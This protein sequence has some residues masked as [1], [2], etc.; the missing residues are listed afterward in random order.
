MLDCK[1][2]HNV[3]EDVTWETSSIREWLN[4]EFYNT[5]FSKEEKKEINEVC[6]NNFDMLYPEGGLAAFG[7]RDTKD[8]IFLLSGDEIWKNLPLTDNYDPSEGTFGEMWANP[9]CTTVATEYAV[10][11]GVKNSGKQWKEWQEKGGTS[12][13]ENKWWK[14]NQD[15]LEKSSDWW[16][17]S[18]GWG[19]DAAAYIFFAGGINYQGEPVSYQGIGVRPALWITIDEENVKDNND[20]EIFDMYVRCA[21]GTVVNEL[22][23]LM[24]FA[25][26]KDM[27]KG[28]YGSWTSLYVITDLDRNGRL[29]LIISDAIPAS[30]Y[31]SYTSGIFEV[32]ET[33]DGLVKVAELESLG[34]RDTISTN[35]YYDDIQQKFYYIFSGRIDEEFN[36]GDW[37][38]EYFISS[39]SLWNGEISQ[40]TLGE[41]TKFSGGTWT[42]SNKEGEIISEEEYLNL[43]TVEY[44]HLNKAT[45]EFVW[46]DF[47]KIE[48]LSGWELVE[49]L[50]DTFR[51][52]TAVT[53]EMNDSKT[54]YEKF[55]EGKTTV[56]LADGF[57]GTIYDIAIHS[58]ELKQG[59][60]L[61]NLIKY[62]YCDIGNDGIKELLVHIGSEKYSLGYDCILQCKDDTLVV[63]YED[64][65][66]T[67]QDSRTYYENGVYSWKSE[68]SKSDATGIW[69]YKDKG[70]SVID[71]NGKC[72]SIYKWEYRECEYLYTEYITIGDKVYLDWSNY[73][74]EPLKE[75][76]EEF[77]IESIEYRYGVIEN[78]YSEVKWIDLEIN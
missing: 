37:Y 14:E 32:N 41:K 53:E 43:E 57:K 74:N 56:Q 51:K 69:K 42:Y 10:A 67:E 75:R 22:D 11:Q 62:T 46:N 27:W 15:W 65:Y 28:S 54:L 18:L 40:N 12:L 78:N 64:L 58:L 7:G 31:F 45:V 6:L 55:L 77:N 52:N 71:A 3:Q 20:N 36:D 19:Q 34:L 29:E 66:K 39:I 30:S 25:Y 21:D 4:D 72:Y 5:A 24:L 8:N 76:C 73:L 9:I 2:Y 70:M 26:N 13:E 63:C 33:Y 50:R 59:T 60:S 61:E 35:V 44:G 23:Q 38:Y 68:Y 47:E 48:D 16:C 1:P 49:E 17:R